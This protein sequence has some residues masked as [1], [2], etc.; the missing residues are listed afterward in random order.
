MNR[1]LASGDETLMPLLAGFGSQ[2]EQDSGSGLGGT[3]G[4]TFSAAGAFER[5]ARIAQS[6]IYGGDPTFTRDPPLGD[7]TE[8][9]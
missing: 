4:A 5:I 9:S 7:F 8:I 1:A 3:F 6:V 2:P